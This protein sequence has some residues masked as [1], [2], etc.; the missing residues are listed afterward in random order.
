M[1]YQCH[2]FL[3]GH[4]I[5]PLLGVFKLDFVCVQEANGTFYCGWLVVCSLIEVVLQIILEMLSLLSIRSG[6][7]YVRFHAL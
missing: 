3:I 2:L 4:D 7:E 1:F 6:K 5:H